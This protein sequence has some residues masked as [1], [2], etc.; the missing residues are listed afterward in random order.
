MGF[1]DSFMATT[2]HPRPRDA[3]KAPEIQDN[4]R[5][6]GQTFIFGKSDAGERVDE[7]SAMQIATVLFVH[8]IPQKT[9]EM[10]CYLSLLEGYIGQ[11]N[12][13]RTTP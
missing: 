3:P 8:I 9:A 2:P 6:S 1:F 4:V 7:K 10:T 13:G 11:Q 12:E 5:D